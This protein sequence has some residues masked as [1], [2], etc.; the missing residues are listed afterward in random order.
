[1]GI[2]GFSGCGKSTLAR[3]I[4][5]IERPDHGKI[6]YRGQDISGLHGKRRKHICKT[7]QIVFQDARASLN[8]RRSA[9]EIV[10][11]PLKYLKIGTPKERAEKALLYLNSVGIHGDTL[12]RCPPQLSTGQCQRIAIAR[13]LVVE[14]DVLICDEA[15]SA[16]DMILQKQ[17]L[18][19]LLTLQ[20]S[21]GFAHIMIYRYYFH[22]TTYCENG[23]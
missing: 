16:L 15:V 11:E 5:G 19:L 22:R 10:Q 9:L 21:I 14:P 20:Q 7:L 13:A 4:T 8:P 18:E 6:L 3:C 17:I 23:E 2:L 12:K 1:M